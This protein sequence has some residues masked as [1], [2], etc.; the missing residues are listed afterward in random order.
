MLL[1]AKLFITTAIV[2]VILFMVYFF[3]FG[4]RNDGIMDAPAMM[5]LGSFIGFFVVLLIKLWGR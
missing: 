4:L 2:P 3:S 5:G 1:F